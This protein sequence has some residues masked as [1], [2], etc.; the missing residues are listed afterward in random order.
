MIFLT[1]LTPYGV[2]SEPFWAHLAATISPNGVLNG[3]G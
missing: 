3:L 1:L 2:L